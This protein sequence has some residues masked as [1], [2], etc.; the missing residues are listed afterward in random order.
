MTSAASLHNV[1]A[2]MSIS[3]QAKLFEHL[4]ETLNQ[5]RTKNIS[6]ALTA[7]GRK[8]GVFECTY[9][10]TSNMWEDL[11]VDSHNGFNRHI[12][13]LFQLAEDDGS[14]PLTISF[15]IGQ[16]CR[17]KKT[18]SI[19]YHSYGSCMTSEQEYKTGNLGGKFFSGSLLTNEAVSKIM[20]KFGKDRETIRY[21]KAFVKCIC[22]I[23]ECANLLDL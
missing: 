9:I 13:M 3:E 15:T 19:S 4:K 22:V 2:E 18:T 12:F 23:N 16:D 20:E 14:N 17:V 10:A 5:K 11:Q 21:A 8:T 6:D 1:I 7:A